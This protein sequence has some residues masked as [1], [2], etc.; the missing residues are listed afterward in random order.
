[1]QIKNKVSIF[2]H[3]KHWSFSKDLRFNSGNP[4]MCYRIGPLRIDV[5]NSYISY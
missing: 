1:M 5:F 4:Y 2:V 3:W